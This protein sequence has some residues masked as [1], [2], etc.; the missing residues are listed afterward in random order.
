MTK[1]DAIEFFG[2]V[3]LTAHNCRV[4][5]QAVRQWPEE[6]TPALEAKVIHAG[7]RRYGLP[8]TKKAFPKSFKPSDN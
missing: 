1:N 7:L 3:E 4:T 8:K 5:G 2:G 6:L